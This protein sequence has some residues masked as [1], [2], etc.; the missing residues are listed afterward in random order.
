MNVKQL[1]NE[2]PC[3]IKVHGDENT[4]VLSLSADS[5]KIEPGA[6]F[7]CI[8]GIKVDAHEFAPQ[9]VA[10]GASVLVVERELDVDATQIVVTDVRLAMSYIA[11]SFYGHPARGM[12]MIGI[13]G[14]KGKS[15][16]CFL[17]K[18]ILQQ[19]GHKVG[20]I[21]TIMTMIGDK[22]LPADLTTPDPIELQKLLRQMADEGV[23]VV[24]MEV[25][26]HALA[27]HKLDGMIY[28]AVA[29]T[30]LSHDHLDFFGTPENY[31]A[32]KCRLLTPEFAKYALLNGDDE[33]AAS[34]VDTLKIPHERFAIREK[35]NIYAG[36]IEFD[37]RGLSFMMHFH[38]RYALEIH[39]KLSGLFNVYN[40]LCAAAVCDAIGI[41]PE[42]IKAGLEE[43]ASVPG[44][45]EVLDTGTQ[46]QVI[47]DYAHSPDSLDNVLRA[48][49]QFTN[50]RLIAVFGCGG[51]R[52]RE[53]RPIMGRIG[54]ELADYCVLTSDNPRGENPMDILASIEEGARPEGK[55]YSVIEN[56]REA[57]KHALKIAQPGD[58]VL[59]AGKGHETYQEIMG[60]K[61][62][63][64]EKVVV[65]ELL[66]ELEM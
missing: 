42:Y 27:L 16:T 1:I 58:V 53:K 4:Q 11:Q 49:R 47:L 23:D 34:I 28:D 26:A 62:P 61:H 9:A 30:N 8:H 22:R 66:A 56:R 50:G 52:D 17:I 29:F 10:A 37:A 21:G 41:A 64:D 46:Y 13:T 51:N 48:V 14:T 59:L 6:L 35:A 36:D 44:R 57:I 31:F 18:S 25:S 55:P 65:Q 33:H 40:S 24:T 54:A 39:L 38:K 45:M 2:L 63:F 12:K 19:A 60:E 7:F 43:I 3:L 20:L 15:T 32:A 5:R